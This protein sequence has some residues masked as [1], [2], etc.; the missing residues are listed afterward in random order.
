[1][2]YLFRLVWFGLKLWNFSSFY[3]LFVVFALGL[4]TSLTFSFPPFYLCVV[5]IYPCMDR[6]VADR[7]LDHG[8]YQTQ[9]FAQG[10]DAT[11]S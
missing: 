7:T 11:S 9:R 4:F 2:I 5:P 1:M 6:G 3:M 8:G 10:N